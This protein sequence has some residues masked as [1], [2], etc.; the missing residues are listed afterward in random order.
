MM[1]KYAIALAVLLAVAAFVSWAFLPARYLPNNRARSL[2]LRLHLRLHPGK[3]FATV[4]SL[5]LYW[6]RLAIAAPLPPDP[7]LPSALAAA[8]QPARAFGVPRPGP[9]PPRPAGPAGGAPAADGAAAN[10]QDRIPG[11][12][13]PDLPRPGNRH[14]HQ[15]RRVRAH[16]RGA[17]APRSRARVQ[18]ATHRRSPLDVPLVACRRMRGP[19]DGHPARRRIRFRRLPQGRRG[20]YVLV[21]QGQRLPARLL[22]RRRADGRRPADGGGLGIR[23]RPARPGTGPDRRRCAAS[24]R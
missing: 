2:R 4:F 14:H 5:W 20:R 11:R 12:R 8:P 13:D 21:R 10:L 19:G 18:P 3:G 22:P 24:G 9:L 17:G 7:P 23:S 1:I 16:R 6:G 15:G